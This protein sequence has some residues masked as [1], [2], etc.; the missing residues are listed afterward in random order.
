[1]QGSYGFKTFDEISKSPNKQVALIEK[2]VEKVYNLEDKVI[3]ASH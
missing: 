1:M 3:A 2:I